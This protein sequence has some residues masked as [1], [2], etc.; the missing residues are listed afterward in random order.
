MTSI[1]LKIA[2]LLLLLEVIP[3]LA[4]AEAAIDVGSRKQLFI[5]HRFIE[6]SHGVRLTMNP[7]IQ[8]RRVLLKPDQAWEGPGAGGTIGP[9]SSILKE[10]GKIRLWYDQRQYGNEPFPSVLRVCYAE[11]TDGLVFV[12]P[13]LRLY[14][15]DGSLENNVVL[16]DKVGGSAVWID[17]QAPP[18]HRYKT[19]AKVYPSGELHLHSSPD[20]H[21]WKLLA[22]LDPGPGGWDTQ[23]I[24]FWEPDLSRYLL[25]TRYWTRF[26]NR[27]LNFRSVRRLESTDLRQWTNQSIVLAPDAMDRA[28]HSTPTGQPPVD[29]CG[30]DV[31][32]YEEADDVYILLAQAFWHWQPRPPVSGLGP[33][34]MDVRLLVSRDGKQFRR[35][36]GR[37]PFLR[38][39]APGGFDS[40]R[41]WALPDPIRMGD[42]IWIYYAGS[43]RDHDRQLDPAA[44]EHLTGVARAV[45]RLD[46][47]VSADAD[48]AGGTLTTPLIRFSGSS[49]ELN[50]DTGGGGSAQVEILDE[51]SRP[52]GGFTLEDAHP[53]NGNS[54]RLPVQWRTNSDL[55]ALSGKPVRLRF[56]LQDSK[57][58]A[59][60]FK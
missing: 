34:A 3:T 18:N 20:G 37:Q 59:F 56:H 29:Y 53:L 8:D 30:A 48:Y 26:D 7:P 55:T 57:L 49:L 41:V 33:S 17:P 58:Y 24:I 5:D 38:M 42:E 4:S 46:G 6:S 11:S 16:A 25:F 9:Y 1:P 21:R 36:G 10:K 54:V 39:G 2:G 22:K 13:H 43:N 15:S 51:L 23:S 12:K 52:I 47:F 45:L 31:F 60:Q 27:D 35:M 14:E 28:T 50:L 32:R 19:Q 40:R 44:S